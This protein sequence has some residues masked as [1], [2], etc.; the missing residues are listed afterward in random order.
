MHLLS[1]LPPNNS[2]YRTQWLRSGL[3]LKCSPP[4]TGNY[5][6]V[7]LICFE[8]PSALWPAI[9]RLYKSP[10]WEDVLMDPF[11][12]LCLVYEAWYQLVDE[13]AWKVL[14]LARELE[15]VCFGPCYILLSNPSYQ[16][17][18]QQAAALEA[19]GSGIFSINYNHIHRLAKEGLHL[20]EGVDGALRSLDRAIE[21]HADIGR[22]NVTIHRA[23]QDALYHRREMFHSTRLRLLS[24]DQRLKN[25]INFV[26]ATF[27]LL[28]LPSNARAGL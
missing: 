19:A 3:V 5:S 8:P 26:C 21:T 18:F 17:I 12:L 7:T 22:T 4:S 13:N 20:I 1:T 16:V 24:V 2:E 15:E 25:V 14:D 11:L 23:T 10:D 27:L 28:R 9:N 6:K